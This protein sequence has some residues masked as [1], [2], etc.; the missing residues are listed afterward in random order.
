MKILLTSDLH[1]RDEYKIN[2]EHMLEDISKQKFDV[3]LIAGDLISYDQTQMPIILSLIRRYINQRVIAV[4]G[5]HD[6]WDLKKRNPHELYIKNTTLMADYGI[7]PLDFH[8]YLPLDDEIH[9]YGWSGWYGQEPYSA[10]EKHM[11]Q[12]VDGEWIHNHLREFNNHNWERV[13][14]YRTHSIGEKHILLTHFNMI[15]QYE[16]GYQMDGNMD[17]QDYINNKFDYC[18]FGHSH[19]PYKDLHGRCWWINSGSYYNDPKYITIHV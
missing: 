15:P 7:E 11:K 8:S 16:N 1:Y 2:I 18:L 19:K 6:Y 17:L 13:L 3:L 14:Y 9:L 4:L 12:Y 10:D 5:N